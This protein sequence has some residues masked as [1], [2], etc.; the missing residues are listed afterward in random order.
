MPCWQLLYVHLQVAAWLCGREGR[1]WICTTGS[2]RSF[3]WIYLSL[4][5][6]TW[7]GHLLRKVIAVL[8]MWW[9]HMGH[10]EKTNITISHACLF[11]CAMQ[12]LSRVLS[13]FNWFIIEYMCTWCALEY[14]RSGTSVWGWE[15][16]LDHFSPSTSTW[17]LRVQLPSLG[18][19]SKCL[20]PLSFLPV[21]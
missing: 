15:K 19:C 12:W 4:W 21:Q 5:N 17:I 10:R 9:G 16:L 1:Y 18:L 8:K 2:T 11:L 20:Y 6:S 13:F 7:E 14:T 3:I